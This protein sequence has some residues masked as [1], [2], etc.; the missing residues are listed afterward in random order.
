MCSRLIYLQQ[1]YYFLFLLIVKHVLMNTNRQSFLQL[2]HWIETKYHGIHNN[3]TPHI[4]TLV[5]TGHD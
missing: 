2:T 3:Q 5:H 1:N 4:A